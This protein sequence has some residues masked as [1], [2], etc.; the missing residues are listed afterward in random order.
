MS[1][2]DKSPSINDL[3]QELSDIVAW[4]E[5]DEFTPE[6]AA[7]KFERADALVR[8]IEAQLTEQKNRI[9]VLKQRFDSEAV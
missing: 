7:D 8:T 4:F 3:R 9:T 2:N 6:A 5:G 1:K